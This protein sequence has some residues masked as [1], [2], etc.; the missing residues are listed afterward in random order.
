M[1]QDALGKRL[2]QHY[3]QPNVVNIVE[4]ALAGIGHGGQRLTP[5]DLASLDEFHV[6]GRAATL[7]LVQAAQLAADQHVLD[8][9]S[10]LGGASR[11]I[12]E[13]VGCRVT[14]IDLSPE[15]CEIANLLAQRVGL[16]HLV[17]YRTANALDLPFSDG[18]FDVV[19]TQH[20]AMNIPDKK[21]LYREIVRVLRPGGT[22]AIYDILAGPV[23]PLRYPVPWARTPADS[24]LVSPD[25]LRQLLSDAG[26]RLLTWQDTTEA[27]RLWF[28]GLVRRIRE[29]GLPP[30]GFHLMLGDDFKTMAENLWR[31]LEE[32]RV[33]LAQIVATT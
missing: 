5:S 30:L 18:T 9:G 14:G 29:T 27:G 4:A 10:G 1:N 2:R 12:A 15:Y 7:E 13:Q 3:A 6:R 17:T 22:L 11:C 8:V 26:V 16:S 23:G 19:W 24:F 28:E 32:E 20:V 21:S 33:V 31:N 25:Q